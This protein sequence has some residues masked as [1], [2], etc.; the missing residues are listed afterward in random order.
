MSCFC[1]LVSAS[2]NR[3]VRLRCRGG[4]AAKARVASVRRHERDSGDQG[5]RGLGFHVDEIGSR[6]YY[7]WRCSTDDARR[8]YAFDSKEAE[9]SA[10]AGARREYVVAGAEESR[11]NKMPKRGAG[12]NGGI[13]PIV[14]GPRRRM[15]KAESYA[16]N[17]AVVDF[18]PARTTTGCTQ[19]E[20]AAVQRG[21]NEWVQELIENGKFRGGSQLQPTAMAKTVR[22]QQRK[23]VVYDG[24]FA[25]TKE[26][27]GVYRLIEC[28]NLEEALAI[29]ARSP[30]ARCGRHDQST[31]D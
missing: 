11:M 27:L 16:D 8:T 22:L 3:E 1:F 29:A 6:S 25:E 28:D 9:W 12:A 15:K 2:E 21:Y 18:A 13:G 14:P 17:L 19:F 31:R 20:R 30:D 10:V 4:S 26:H 7:A 23:L 5:D 24:P